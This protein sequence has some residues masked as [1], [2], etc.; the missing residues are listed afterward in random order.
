MKTKIQNLMLTLAWFAGA[1]AALAQGS[2][3]AFQ[4]RLNNGGAPA[5]GMYDFRLKKAPMKANIRFVS[6]DPFPFSVGRG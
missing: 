5:N 1:H 4:G 2:A 6:P 3:F